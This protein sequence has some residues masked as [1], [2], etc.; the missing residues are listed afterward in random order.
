MKTRTVLLSLLGIV[1]TAAALDGAA[2]F[3]TTRTTAAGPLD[4]SAVSKIRVEGEAGRL[5]ISASAEGPHEARLE[6]ERRGFGALWR[7]GWF[8]VSCPE[9]GMHID[10]DTLVVD[11]GGTRFYRWSDCTMT[12]TARLR[13]QAAVAIDQQASQT[14]LQGDFS[15]VD[16]R[17]DAGDINLRGHAAQLSLSGAALRARVVFDKVMQNETIALTGNMLDAGLRFLVPTPVSYLVEATASYVD[18]TLPNTPGA[19]PAIHVRGD[20]VRVRIE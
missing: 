14:D 16:I 9:G 15:T 8:P 3:V 10:G 18:S 17:S 13:P 1:L 12:L 19:K 20:M 2:A 6:G 7:S 4:L 11:L 5:F